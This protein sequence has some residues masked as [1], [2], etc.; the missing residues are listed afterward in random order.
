MATSATPGRL[1]SDAMSPIANTSGWPGNREVGVD[2]RCVR[3]GRPRRRSPRRAWPPAATPARRRPRSSCTASMRDVRAV[4][5]GRRRR[6]ARPRRRPEHPCAARRRAARGPLAAL[7]DS[8]SP[9]VAS[10]SLAAVEQQHADRWPDRRCGT[11]RR[12][13]RVASS[14]TCP[15]SSTP[16][17]PA[18]TITIVSHSRRSARV[19]RRLGHLERAEDPPAQLAARRRSSSCPAR[20]GRTRRGRS[21]TGSAP[22]ATIRLS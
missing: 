9:K 21:T 14:R 19:G 2:A 3:P 16:V 20:T 17:G 22:A 4:R 12:R 15:A 5:A 10:G 13:Q 6:R 1:L 18:P 7:P 11:R 8:W